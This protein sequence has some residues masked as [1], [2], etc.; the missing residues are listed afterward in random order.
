M[1]VCHGFMFSRINCSLHPNEV[2]EGAGKKAKIIGECFHDEWKN[3][4]MKAEFKCG[5]SETEK[6]SVDVRILFSPN[7]F[8]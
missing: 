8:E 2:V 4:T 3:R 1:K 5:Y 6:I 7:T